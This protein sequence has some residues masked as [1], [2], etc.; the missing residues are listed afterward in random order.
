MAPE[1]RTALCWYGT[2]LHTRARMLHAPLLCHTP[3]SIH[4]HAYV[5]MSLCLPSGHLVAFFRAAFCTAHLR[6]KHELE[7]L[8]AAA[9]A[10]ARQTVH[11]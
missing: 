2:T 4:M 9:T 8:G 3:S 5:C 7:S 10:V 1:R 6:P 11:R